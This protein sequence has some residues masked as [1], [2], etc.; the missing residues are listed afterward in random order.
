MS[1]GNKAISA[2]LTLAMLVGLLP[3]IGG[4]ARADDAV[5]YVYYETGAEGTSA[6]NGSCTSFTLITSDTTVWNGTGEGN[7]Y[8]VNNNIDISDRVTVSG[9]VHLILCDGCSLFA[10]EGI[11][12]AAGNTL[13]IYAQSDG[14][15]ML[16]AGIDQ[17][18]QEQCSTAAAGI[19]GDSD[20]DCG[21]VVI[22]GGE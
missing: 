10:E 18:Y 5:P 20:D 21:S 17:S 19:G 2:L 6:K 15:G 16:C 9:T 11:T 22:H 4:T 12:V 8:V 3:A 13:N 7:W 14:T 1:H